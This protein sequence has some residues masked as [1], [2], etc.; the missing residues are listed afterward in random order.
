MKVLKKVGI[1]LT[2]TLVLFSLLAIAVPATSFAIAGTEMTRLG[3][4]AADSD[5]NSTNSQITNAFTG[6]FL[7]AYH[8]KIKVNLNNNFWVNPGAFPPKDTA[9]QPVVTFNDMLSGIYSLNKGCTWSI[10][11]EIKYLDGS[12]PKDIYVEGIMAR[13]S[14][15][16]S[17]LASDVGGFITD[18]I[19]AIGLG[20][21]LPGVGLLIG[22][23][24]DHSLS[25]DGTNKC[26]LP[27]QGAS[28]D[29]LS[30]W[31]GSSAPN[32]RF[33]LYVRV[34]DKGNGNDIVLADKDDGGIARHDWSCPSCDGGFFDDNF[35]GTAY[36]GID[37]RDYF[38]ADHTRTDGLG[39]GYVFADN[40]IK[41]TYDAT[42][43]YAL[44]PGLHYFQQNN[45]GGG[46]KITSADWGS[47]ADAA[48]LAK[49]SD[50]ATPDYISVQKI[51][52]DGTSKNIRVAKSS[53]ELAALYTS[54]TLT[55]PDGSSNTPS[56]ESASTLSLEWFLCPVI[57]GIDSTLAGIQSVVESILTI[58]V[59]QIEN[60][61][62]HDS[63][64][65]IR[66][67]ASV[68][69]VIFA[70]IMVISTALDIGPF[71]AYT[72][73][74]V[75]PRLVIAVIAM[76][77]SWSI[78][79]LLIKITND[80]GNG[81]S[82][83]MLAPFGGASATDL[84][85]VIAQQT[86]GPAGAGFFTAAV[87]GAG[88]VTGVL[89][90]IMGVLSL[91][92]TTLVG[93]L[94]GFA[95]LILRN[96]VII[97]CLI[98]APIAIVCFIIPG[99]EKVGKLWWESFSKGLMMFPLILIL[100]TSG[101]IFAHITSSTTA[102]NGSGP[103]VI[104]GTLSF[105]IVVAAYVIPYFLIP[106][107]FKL[108]GGAL[109]SLGGMVNNKGR[110]FF[111]RN[112]KY[113]GRKIAENSA[114]TKNFSRFSDRSALGRG[115]NSILGAGTHPKAALRGRAG[116]RAARQ[117]G[118]AN[119]GAE[120]LKNDPT[121]QAHGQD[122]NFLVALADEDLA[123][124]KIN[125]DKSDLEV[126]RLRSN[127]GS[128]SMVERRE[129]TDKATGLQTSINAREKGLNA[130]RQ[131]G[132]RKQAS[133]R[134]AATNALA[135]TGYQFSSGE[136]GYNELSQT[137]RSITGSDEG[138]YSAAMDEAQ[139]HLKGAARFDLAGINHGAGYDPGAGLAK[140]SLYELANG[141]KE[142]ITAMTS[143]LPAVGPWTQEQNEEAAV[144]YQELSSMRPNAKGGNLVEIDKQMEMLSSKAGSFI[145]DRTGRMVDA[146]GATVAAGTPGA[147]P[148]GVQQ[149]DNFDSSNTDPAY[150]ATWA[151]PVERDRGWR[152]RVRPET[153]ADVARPKARTYQPPDPNVL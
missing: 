10:T 134:L 111:D 98:L 32:H 59:S 68:L 47:L 54:G 96:I 145:N 97:M 17:S 44:C 147:R 124:R 80:F 55:N 136:E 61:Q 126:Q 109:A 81:I 146:T 51:A 143:S 87:I 94:I 108:A 78:M 103:G 26:S 2:L 125:K 88:V 63:W 34:S 33:Q 42:L 71:D 140:A 114:K 85:A 28:S 105:V 123:V 69:L 93:V 89:L 52:S 83:L 72:I 15:G 60:G 46:E 18:H 23:A 4:D 91:A 138:A 40:S 14:I 24:V 65:A 113:R 92:L 56:C 79:I 7:D 151:D 120:S 142:S 6:K 48:I 99:T 67:I 137:V 130:A 22:S 141:K 116:I 73:R 115:V 153:N 132:N 12:T 21:A 13:N 129:A 90:G 121:F 101:R 150:L 95:V 1:C 11:H 144:T 9:G 133:V 50:S 37:L 70:L 25:S 30:N 19:G 41:A 45:C 100:F 84:G 102:T 20:I 118:R 76:Q 77:L 139:Y 36:W 82:S 62:L 57:K 119:F 31:P 152:T 5:P 106:S 29:E 127:D 53:S 135:K 112:K 107:T 75:L 3:G 148:A 149:R 35:S 58:N 117:T 86:G 49:F 131:V 16:T 74:K 39:I 128:L 43:V 122:D 38:V 66:N 27:D 104:T 8:M 64:G 110:G